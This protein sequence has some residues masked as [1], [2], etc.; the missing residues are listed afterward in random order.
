MSALKCSIDQMDLTDFYGIF[1]STSVEY[2]FSQQPMELSKIDHILRHKANLY[3]YQK[4][5]KFLVSSFFIL[6][7]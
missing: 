6:K 5:K 1:Q 3:K 2:T 4:P 7:S